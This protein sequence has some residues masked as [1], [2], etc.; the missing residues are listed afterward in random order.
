[1]GDEG[2]SSGRG[3]S[4]LTVIGEPVRFY[5]ADTLKK[6]RWWLRAAILANSGRRYCDI[7]HTYSTLRK[8]CSEEE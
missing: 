6:K 8:A 7:S 5:L 4:W 1:V 2:G 3:N